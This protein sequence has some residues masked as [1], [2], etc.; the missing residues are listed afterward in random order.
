MEELPPSVSGSSPVVKEDKPGWK[1]ELQEN[2]VTVLLAMGL[3]VG[4]RS[5]IAEPR[6]IPSGSMLPTLEIGDRL[7]VEKLSYRFRLPERGDIIVFYP[8]KELGFEGAYIKR[9]IGLPGD[10]I[11]IAEG[12]VY[13]NGIP[14][15]EVYIE[16][17]P[18]YTCP[19][20]CGIESEEDTFTVPEG[21]YFVMGD[22]RNDSQD[23]HVWGFLPKENII[24]RTV[25]RFWPLN[26]LYYFGQETYS[27]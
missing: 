13:I 17:P 3:A 14:L 9:A 24:G 7:V 8:P 18:N 22:N 5:V 12:L 6:W 26:R 2:L 10:K 25:L 4:C 15:S 20:Q 11:R 1:K 27:Q 21:S 23:S 19:G 16:S